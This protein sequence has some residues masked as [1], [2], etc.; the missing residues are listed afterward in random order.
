[1]S[2]IHPNDVVLQRNRY[3]EELASV[4]LKQDSLHAVVTSLR[5]TNDRLES[6]NVDLQTQIKDLQKQIARMGSQQRGVRSRVSSS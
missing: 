4:R 3:R 5:N 1:M 2:T 6:E